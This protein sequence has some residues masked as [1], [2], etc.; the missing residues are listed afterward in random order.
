MRSS[1]YD[2]ADHS[3]KK[4]SPVSLFSPLATSQAAS[5]LSRTLN[6]PV[7][8]D[9]LRLT[10]AGIELRGV[11]IANDP[12]LRV[13]WLLQVQHV[14]ILPAWREWLR[15]KRSVHAVL[16]QA[17]KMHLARTAN[18][19]WNLQQLLRALPKAE[20]PGPEVRIGRLQISNGSIAAPDTSLQQLSLEITDLYTRGSHPLT[21]SLAARD[22]H[23]ATLSA[24]GTAQLGPRP[25]ASA[26]LN[27]TTPLHRLARPASRLALDRGIAT[28]QVRVALANGLLTGHGDLAVAGA[29]LRTRGGERAVKLHLRLH[30]DYALTDDL[31]R[32]TTARLDLDGL[33]TL[34]ASGTVADLRG[35][36]RFT[37]DLSL[38][39]LDLSAL[40][41]LA[42]LPAGLE[43]K[44]AITEA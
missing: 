34:A 28:A 36:R 42:P 44:G 24:T 20:K 41:Q 25:I 9:G 15:G 43:V 27:L 22:P 32:L 6:R 29:A 40:R 30:G 38:S 13:P 5:L 10:S 7:R 35:D 14:T 4:E 16:F 1:R 23:G 8:L 12:F 39:P 18:G 17:P 21:Y 19:E 31:L 33:A 26:T 3:P 2:E 37:V 11:R